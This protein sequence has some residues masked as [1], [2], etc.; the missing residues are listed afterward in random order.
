MA[1][2][3]IGHFKFI[4][5]EEIFSIGM[6]SCNNL[7]SFLASSSGKTSTN[8]A[9]SAVSSGT[10]ADQAIC[11]SSVLA[12]NNS[13]GNA[14]KNLLSG[15]SCDQSSSLRALLKLYNLD[16]SDYLNLLNKNGFHSLNSLKGKM[17]FGRRPL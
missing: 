2:G 4:T 16:N 8:C 6:R 9:N 15:M 11:S 14:I 13:D 17:S 3:K 5:V 10:V 12:V 7:P 1:N